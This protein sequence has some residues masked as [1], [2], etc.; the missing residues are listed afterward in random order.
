MGGSAVTALEIALRRAQV[1]LEKICGE[2]RRSR[3]GAVSAQAR[4]RDAAGA[5]VQSATVRASGHPARTKNSP[6]R[7]FPRARSQ[8]SLA[9]ASA[10]NS[11]PLVGALASADLRAVASQLPQP[12]IAERTRH[13]AGGTAGTG[14]LAGSPPL[15]GVIATA[16]AVR[17]GRSAQPTDLLH[18][19]SCP[20]LSTNRAF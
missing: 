14:V 4:V 13:H 1:H 6:A 15:R 11:G 17:T 16:R 18:Q 5:L 7:I 2:D 8:A 9:G 19:Q 12:G 3:L 20:G 10:R